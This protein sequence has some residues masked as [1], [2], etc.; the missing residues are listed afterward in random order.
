MFTW[1]IRQNRVF[2]LFNESASAHHLPDS[3]FTSPLFKIALRLITFLCRDPKQRDCQGI[4]Q[5]WNY[6]FQFVSKYFFG[7]FYGCFPCFLFSPLLILITFAR[8]HSSLIGCL[9]AKCLNVLGAQRLFK[10]V[11]MLCAFFKHG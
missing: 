7:Y 1:N 10:R 11:E 9:I 6:L 8:R 2:T 5:Q 3:T 4:L